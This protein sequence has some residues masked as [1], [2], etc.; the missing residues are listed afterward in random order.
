[1]MR[2]TVLFLVALS[3][4]ACTTPPPRPTTIDPALKKEL[5]DAVAGPAPKKPQAPNQALL[6]PLR[7]ELPGVAGRPMEPRFDLS[8]SNAPAPQVF[9]AIASGTRY[10]MLLN[11]EVGGSITVNLKDVTVREALDSLRELYG[12]EYRI[13]GNRIFVQPAGLQTKIYRVNYLQGKRRGTSELRVQSSSLADSAGQVAAPTA[14]SSTNPVPPLG[15]QVSGTGGVAQTV[16]ASRVST[17]IESDL[18]G[19]LRTATRAIG[20]S[21]EG[22]GGGWCSGDNGGGEGARGEDW[23]GRWARGDARGAGG[24]RAPWGERDQG[25]GGWHGLVD[26]G[27]CGAGAGVCG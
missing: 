12:Y 7:M 17:T 13:D 6:P 14:V 19:D 27:G 8:V 1:M 15:T 2:T 24:G 21:G 22:R 10:S 20:G 25:E 5:D 18:W 16:E 26:G 9:M 11:P 3:V 4:A 23:H